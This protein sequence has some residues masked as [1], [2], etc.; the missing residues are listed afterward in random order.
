MKQHIQIKDGYKYWNPLYMK[1]RITFGMR[2]NTPKIYA[3]YLIEWWLHNIGYYLTKP[4]TFIPALN[5][6]NL[7]CKDVDLI[8]RVKE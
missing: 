3:P 7:R 6:I 8:V 4:F 2:P 5:R 1:H